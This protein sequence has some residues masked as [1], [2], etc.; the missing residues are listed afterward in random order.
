MLQWIKNHYQLIIAIVV[1]SLLAVYLYACEPKVRSLENETVLV[2]RVELQAELDAVLKRA[3][4]RMLDLDK[5]EAIRS[6]ILQNGLILLEG[7][8]LNP[9]GIIS[10]LAAI[11]GVSQIGSKTITAVKNGI[12]KGKVNNG[13]G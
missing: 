6:L 4:H 8:P 7:Q 12:A 11:Y 9:F 5:Q 13:T 10:A 2:T 1:T 3:E